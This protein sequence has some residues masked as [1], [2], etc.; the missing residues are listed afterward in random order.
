MLSAKQKAAELANK[1]VDRDNYQLQAKVT[2]RCSVLLRL[3]GD[4]KASEGII[5]SFFSR[6]SSVIDTLAQEDLARLCLSQANNY[7]YH[8]RFEN[9]HE[10]M[11]KARS[12]VRHEASSLL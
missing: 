5:Q 9:A 6:T 11:R 7:A 10:E 12:W 3:I 4:I 8:L 2:Y 1:L